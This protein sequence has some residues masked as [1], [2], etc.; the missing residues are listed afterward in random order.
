MR[1]AILLVALTAGL[2]SAQ[3]FQ[4]L[5]DAS[6]TANRG[7]YCT[8]LAWGDYDGDGTLDLYAPNWG[9]A[10]WLSSTNTRARSGKY[11]KSVGGGSPGLRPE[12]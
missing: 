5:S 10:T 4:N 9:T 11:S 6:G 8:N 7:L 3:S 1:R 2:A 12:R